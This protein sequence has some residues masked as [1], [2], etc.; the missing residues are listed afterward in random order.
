MLNIDLLYFLKK[1]RKSLWTSSLAPFKYNN[2]LNGKNIYTVLSNSFR[3]F[4]ITSLKDN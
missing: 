2:S 4:V 1:R 3:D